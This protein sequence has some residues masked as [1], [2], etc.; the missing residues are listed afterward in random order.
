VVFFDVAT[1]REFG[2]RKTGTGCE[3]ICLLP[4]GKRALIAVRN[5]NNVME[6]DLATMSIVRRFS[7]GEGPDGMAWIGQ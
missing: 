2:R 7:T 4:G 5:D 6:V 3:G 1:H